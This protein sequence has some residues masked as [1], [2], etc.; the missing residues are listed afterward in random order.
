MVK[1]PAN[2]ISSG[3]TTTRKLILEYKGESAG[4][5][6]SVWFDTSGYIAGG[7]S[8]G[9]MLL[10]RLSPKGTK[11]WDKSFDAGFN[12][13]YSKLFYTGSGTLLA[14]GTA[15]P[16][17][18]GSGATGLLFVRFDTTGNI[19]KVKNITRQLLS[20][21]ITRLLI[22]RVIFSLLLQGKVSVLKQRPVLQNIMISFRNCGKQIF[23]IIPIS[24]QP[25]WQ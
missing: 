21:Q 4:L 8:G 3:L 16:D 20:L 25:V 23:L 13:D 12:V 24:E 7:N 5:F 22:I 18:S 10:A 19:I 1:L 11:L 15:S 17:S 6:S 2:H 14:I 9:K